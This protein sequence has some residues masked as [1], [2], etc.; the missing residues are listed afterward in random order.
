[1]RYLPNVMRKQVYLLL[2]AN[3]ELNLEWTAKRMGMH[4]PNQ[5]KQMMSIVRKVK[6]T[7]INENGNIA[8]TD[9]GSCPYWVRYFLYIKEHPNASTI[10]MANAFNKRQTNVLSELY[11]VREHLNIEEE[12]HRNTFTLK[13]NLM[14]GGR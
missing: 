7:G 9:I 3:G 14:N 2:I 10:E 11:R 4:T 12:G 8:I 1:M 13:E 6:G 5:K